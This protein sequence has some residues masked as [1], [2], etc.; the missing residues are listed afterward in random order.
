MK[1]QK[2]RS[3]FMKKI[4]FYIPSLGG[5]GAEKV[6]ITLL[7]KLNKEKYSITVLTNTNEGIYFDNMPDNIKIIYLFNKEK[8][9]TIKLY[10]K[11]FKY[12]PAKILYKAF[13]KD[14]YDFEVTFLE[15][16]GVKL[17]SAS[18]SNSKKIAWIHTDLYNFHWTEN[19]FKNLED[20]K[21]FLDK[22]QKIVCVS[23]DAKVGFEK[24]YGSSDKV[25]VIYNPIDIEEIEKRSLEI[26]MNFNKF[27]I[28]SVGRL[29]D[30]KGYDTL[31]SVHKKLLADGFDHDLIILGEGIKRYELEKEIVKLKVSNS[32]KLLGF[33]SNPY[34][35]IKAC[36]LYVSSSK[37][38]GFPLVIS[39][40]LILKKAILSTYCSGASEI[41]DDGKYGI[42]VENS[43]QGLYKGIKNIFEDKNILVKY[44][45]LADS[46]RQ[47][48]TINKIISHIE[49]IFDEKKQIKNLE[50]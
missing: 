20:E 47:F 17:L 31:I 21:R 35:Y 24:L 48:F 39:E 10:N 27:T 25:E 29:I 13:I 12:L 1:I 6:L 50:E 41:L 19:I 37:V 18:T 26:P 38:E 30:V 28:C 16:E 2:L 44:S 22:F 42:L 45:Q 4:L 43:E 23:N 3:I 34:P 15:G 46:R 33:I 49:S 40:A 36:N 9:L 8:K 11:I 14:S 5:G 7:N 32:V